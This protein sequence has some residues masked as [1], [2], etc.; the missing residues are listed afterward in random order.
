M[1]PADG[2]AA[3]E[4][5]DDDDDTSS[6]GSISKEE[7]KNLLDLLKTQLRGINLNSLDSCYTDKVGRTLDF[8]KHGFDSLLD[9]LKTVKEIR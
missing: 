2:G 9:M 8:R 7:K 3:A 1:W 5:A 4:S 6:T